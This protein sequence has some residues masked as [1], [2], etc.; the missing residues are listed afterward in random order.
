MDRLCGFYHLVSFAT[1]I[2]PILRTLL[3]LRKQNLACFFTWRIED[4]LRDRIESV[5]REYPGKGRK[6]EP[7][8]N[9]E[10]KSPLT[11]GCIYN[12]IAKQSIVIDGNG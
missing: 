6:E 3:S 7:K 8:E 2:I 10:E 4:A 12:Q 9:L 11:L 5:L 1:V